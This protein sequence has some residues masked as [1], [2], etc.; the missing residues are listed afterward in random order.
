VLSFRGSERASPPAAAEASELASEAA[1]VGALPV[2]A[3]SRGLELRLVSPATVAVAFHE[4]A[5]KG[6]V[7]LHPAGACSVCRNRAK[8]TPAAS[9]WPGRSYIVMDSRG[10]S[11]PATSAVDV[12]LPPGT[13]VL[14]PV[15]GTVRNVKRYRLYRR[16]PDIR[17]AIAPAADPRRRVVVIHLRG[18][19]LQRGDRVVASLTVLGRVRSFPFQAQVD[20]YVRGSFPHVHLEVRRGIEARHSTG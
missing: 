16:Y 4:A 13:P 11:T 20:R 15:T 6:A 12:V 3:V 2:F 19:T 10:R 9:S 18:V 17:V 7:T 8:F 1:P 14:A 5:R